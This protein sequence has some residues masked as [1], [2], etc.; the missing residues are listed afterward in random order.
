VKRNLHAGRRRSGGLR[1]DVFTDDEIDD[2][3]LGSLE[4][5]QQTGVFVEDD[6]ALDIFSDGGCDVDRETRMVRI[7]PYVVEDAIKSAPASVVC[8]GRDPKND[9]VSQPGRVDFCNFDEGI[10]VI[11]PYTGEYRQPTIKD[12][13][14]IARL[15]DY[16][17]E[18]GTYESAV[19][20]ADVPTGLVVLA[21]AASALC[22]QAVSVGTS[23]APTADS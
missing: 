9:I 1:L 7:P 13:G 23:A 4:V 19:G 10:M 22:R 15:V 6:E 17:S 8:Y 20:A 12:V 18:M 11:D 3:H 16:L 14:D 5:L 2:I 21:K